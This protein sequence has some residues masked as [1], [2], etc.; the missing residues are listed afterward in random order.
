M[1]EEGAALGL[2]MVDLPEKP[3]PPAKNSD[4][5]ILGL[6]EENKEKRKNS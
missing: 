1:A 3:L 2:F 5:D 6:R 4:E